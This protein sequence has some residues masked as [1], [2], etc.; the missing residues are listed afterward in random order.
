M[1]GSRGSQESQ[2]KVG[3]FFSIPVSRD[4]IPGSTPVAWLLCEITSWQV[5]T[6]YI[7]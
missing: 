1:R 3:A 4:V 2:L 5:L 6:P 7:L